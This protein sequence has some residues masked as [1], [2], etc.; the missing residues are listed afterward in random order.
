M[1]GRTN[2][3]VA[4]RGYILGL[5]AQPAW[6]YTAIQHEQ[7]GTFYRYQ[8]TIEQGSIYAFL[9]QNRRRPNTKNRVDEQ[10]ET[11]VVA[12]AVEQPPHGLTNY[13][14]KV[15]SFRPVVPDVCGCNTNWTA[16]KTAESL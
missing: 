11:A 3:K 16:L 10:T 4:A 1:A 7:W 13:A 12:Y 2:R 14:S 6:F 8:K 9:D 15:F 5:L